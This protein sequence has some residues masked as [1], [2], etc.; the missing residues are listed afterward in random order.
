MSN[1]CN[2][3]FPERTNTPPSPLASLNHQISNL[4]LHQQLGA[5][6]AA[7]SSPTPSDLCTICHDVCSTVF[8]RVTVPVCGHTFCVD[9]LLSWATVR[10]L[11]PNCKASFNSLFVHR[12]E[13]G[14]PVCGPVTEHNQPPYL[15]QPTVMLRELPWVNLSE[16]HS[17][18]HDIEASFALPPI[19]AL[20]APPPPSSSAP[21]YSN[22]DLE[23]ELE[24]RFW[25]E[26]E[27]R[28]NRLMRSTKVV[29]NRRFGPQ[30][31]ISGG[32]MRATPRPSASPA[33]RSKKAM[34]SSS[35]AASAAAQF[36]P[37]ASPT[38]P[39]RAGSTGGRKKKVKK[40]S[41]AGI[42]AAKAAEEAAKAQA[43]KLTVASVNQNAAPSQSQ[44]G[45]QAPGSSHI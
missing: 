1:S 6:A 25:E 29:S 27:H 45:S 39:T 36:H 8:D 35:A 15:L 18:K 40:K 21:H 42:A 44:P 37:P 34:A 33:P 16:I 3:G 23:D 22:E 32:R 19:D 14:H 17:A 7:S 5:S 31:Y 30:G 20:V 12:D 24:H 11:C 28:Y 2:N 4:N 38:K 41:R 9:C 43:E 13:T 26:E 10:E